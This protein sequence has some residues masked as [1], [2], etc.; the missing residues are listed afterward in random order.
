LAVE[1][2]RA[3]EE[4]IAAVR[5]HPMRHPIVHGE[6]RRLIIRRFPYGIFYAVRAVELKVLAIYHLSRDPAGWKSRR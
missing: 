1:F 4:G 3:V 2:A 6:I 5:A